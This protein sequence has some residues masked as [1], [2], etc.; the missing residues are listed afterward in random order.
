MKQ[1]VLETLYEL[2]SKEVYLYAFSLCKDYHQAQDLVSDTFFKALI[3]LK[4]DD[5][6][7][8][9]WLLKVCKNLWLDSLKYK[10]HFTDT[11]FEDNAL[12]VNFTGLEKLINHEHKRLLYKAILTLP[13]N[14]TEIIYMF[15]FC[16]MSLNDIAKEI[17]ISPGAARTLLFRSRQKLK[18]IL[19]EDLS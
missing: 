17:N 1:K 6:N 8:K 7:I 16:N 5:M 2:Y 13:P 12:P 3:A 10:K 11:P 14:C 19:K 9:Y 15:Y 18:N 4:D